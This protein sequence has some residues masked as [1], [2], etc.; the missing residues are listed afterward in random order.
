VLFFGDC[1]WDFFSR[2]SSPQRY[3][4]LGVFERR[5]QKGPG[6]RVYYGLD[7]V[8]LVVLLGGG[9]KSTQEKD[10]EEAKYLWSKYKYENRRLQKIAV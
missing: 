8:N 1:I 4:D 3:R 10:I 2:I 5:I 7:G 9:D 6:L